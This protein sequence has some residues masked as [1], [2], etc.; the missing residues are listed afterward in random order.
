M[1][2][3]I[4]LI[5]TLSLLVIQASFA[6]EIKT[7]KIAISGYVTDVNEKP[8]EGVSIIVDNIESKVFTNK[9][10]YYKV[11]VA[12]DT[13]R[14][15]AY[16]INHGGVEVEYVGHK[17]INFVLLADSTNP[18][19]KSPQLD[20]VYDFGYGKINEKNNT[21]SMGKIDEKDLENVAYKNIYEMIQGKVPG[22]TV[23]GSNITIRGVGS[24][25]AQG[26]P[27]FIVDGFE[28]SSIDSIDPRSVKSIT[29]LK[30]SS[31]AIYGSRGSM[32]VI[33]ITL[34]SGNK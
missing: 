21:S 18:H 2:L 15:M 24:I 26:N 20:K 25:N 34:K 27:L 6:Q 12:P 11:K 14:L 13:K 29:V 7:K 8:L 33:V 5:I 16:A 1:K 31:A 28:T 23:V 22:V 9:K 19:Y 17:K 10:G 3:K 4:M 30:G 32:G